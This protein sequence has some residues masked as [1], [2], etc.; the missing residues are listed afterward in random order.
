MK[1]LVLGSSGFLGSW[2]VHTLRKKYSNAEI[3]ESSLSLGCD[4]R[5]YNETEILFNKS[6]PNFVI[7]CAAHVGGIQYG[8]NHTK[9]LF[10]D[11]MS[12]II[13]VFRACNKFKINRLIQPISNC[14]YPSHLSIYKEEEFWQGPVHDSVFTF[15]ET[16][17]M[18]LVAAKSYYLQDG[19]DTISIVHPNLYGPGDHFEEYRSH[20]LGAL[21]SKII[22][23]KK[24]NKKHVTIWGSGSPIREWLFVEDAALS[25]VNAIDIEPYQDI[26]NIGSGSG[27]SIKKLALM[28]KNLSDW[29]GEF[30][31]DKSKID[32][33]L[34]K[35]IDGKKGMRLLNIDSLK[36]FEEGL[37]E[38]INSIY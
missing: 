37:E 1:V 36:P 35:V 14:A 33:A 23:A 24:E 25:M 2:V 26:I 29:N 16:R 8:L 5:N 4:L 18:M 10:H 30:I 17:R 38:T 27:I 6:S 31:F 11:N 15:A 13:N 20:A 7:N 34:I 28:I 22:H 32:G 3:I 12:M 9:D 19:L 21:I